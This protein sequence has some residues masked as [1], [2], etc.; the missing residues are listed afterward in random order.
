MIILLLEVLGS[1]IGAYKLAKEAY[2]IYN[3]ADSVANY[4]NNYQAYKDIQKSGFEKLT[5]SQYSC[6]E[7]DFVVL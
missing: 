1:G 5:Q 3:D 6:F 2:L 7:E 4:Y